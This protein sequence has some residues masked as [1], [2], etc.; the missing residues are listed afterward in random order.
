MASSQSTIIYLCRVRIDS[1]TTKFVHFFFSIAALRTELWIIFKLSPST[2]FGNWS[3]TTQKMHR[4]EA[5]SEHPILIYIYAQMRISC[6]NTT[7]YGRPHWVPFLSGIHD[8]SLIKSLWW[9]IISNGIH[10]DAT[11]C[12]SAAWL[13]F[14]RRSEN[15][16]ANC[17]GCI[18]N[19]WRL[20]DSLSLG[21]SL[22]SLSKRCGR[23]KNY[24]KKGKKSKTINAGDV[25]VAA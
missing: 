16:A 9:Q 19:K 14:G 1:I 20:S 7:Y 25:Y 17:A 4:S 11:C 2:A 22:S 10:C 5:V 3:I 8:L 23:L 18:M 6:S 13:P 24:E 15:V 21:V 12:D